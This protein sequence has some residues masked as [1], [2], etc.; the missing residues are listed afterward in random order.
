[1]ESDIILEGFSNTDQQYRVRYMNFIGDDDSSVH[2]EC[3]ISDE[4]KQILMWFLGTKM[5][6]CCF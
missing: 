5:Y 6:W 4:G 1:M 3:C 2:T